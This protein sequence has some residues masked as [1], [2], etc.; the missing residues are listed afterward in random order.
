MTKRKDIV[1]ILGSVSQQ[2]CIKRIEEFIS[3]GYSVHVYGFERDLDNPFISDLFKIKIIG[4]FANKLSYKKRIPILIQGIRKVHKEWVNKSNIVFYYFSMD[5]ACISILLRIK[6]Q[7]IYEES[8]L[9]HLYIKNK[10]I[11]NLLE[12]I[13]LKLI[14]KSLLSVFTSE[15]FLEYHYGDKAPDNTF[16]IPNKLNIRVLNLKTHKKKKYNNDNIVFGFVGIPRFNSVFTFAELI[17]ELY[18]QHEFH[19]FGKPIEE[20]TQYS[21]LEK[22]E[23]IYFHGSFKNPDDLPLIYSSIDFVVALYDANLINVRYAEPNKLYESVFFRVPII[24]SDN[25]FLAT[26]VAEFNIGSILNSNNDKSIIEFINSISQERYL[27]LI[28]NL[29]TIPR[30]TA[31]NMNT[32]FFLKLNKYLNNTYS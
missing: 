11:R 16:V 24:V 17:G 15:G 26:K 1:F 6:Q 18:P 29:E 22:Y 3:N 9:R 31:I 19:F 14:E 32:N 21:D 2:R 27:D 20:N 23:N 10:C 30:N 12:Y 7:Y 28:S 5:T 13:D 8:D 4:T 25:T